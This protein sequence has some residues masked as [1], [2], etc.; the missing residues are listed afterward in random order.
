MG[1]APG[2]GLNRLELEKL[3]LPGKPG[4]ENLGARGIVFALPGLCIDGG[5]GTAWRPPLDL[6]TFGLGLGPTLKPE[7]RL[8]PRPEFIFA[9]NWKTVLSFSHQTR[10]KL[11]CSILFELV[12]AC[13]DTVGSTTGRRMNY[14]S[15]NSKLFAHKS[16]YPGCSYI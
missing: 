16:F 12:F 6:F 9:L 13:C 5:G 3:L 15:S 1:P 7:N 14:F 2:A 10:N 4:R 8:P 11:A